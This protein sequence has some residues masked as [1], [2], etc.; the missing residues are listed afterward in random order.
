[1]ADHEKTESILKQSA[2]G[3]ESF[4]K[5][6]KNLDGLTEAIRKDADTR[7]RLNNHLKEF[8]TKIEIFGK[9][10]EDNHTRATEILW[11]SAPEIAKAPCF[12]KFSEYLWGRLVSSEGR[13]F[14]IHF[15]LPAGREVPKWVKLGIEVAQRRA[16]PIELKSEAKNAGMSGRRWS[17]L[18]RVL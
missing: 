2:R 18:R 16:L 9:G 12:P 7:I 17:T 14:R 10:H 13:F 15:K 8:I 5:W 3:L 4:D 1:V 11:E 6:Q